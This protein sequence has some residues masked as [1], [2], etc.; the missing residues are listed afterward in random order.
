MNS[1]PVEIRDQIY[2]YFTRAELFSCMMVCKSWFV[3]FMSLFYKEVNIKTM[4]KLE[5]LHTALMLYPSCIQAV[6]HI[7]HLD[8]SSLI[9][10]KPIGIQKLSKILSSCPQLEILSMP[11]RQLWLKHM[12]AN[13]MPKMASLI[14]IDWPKFY[15]DYQPLMMECCAKY[16]S[17][18]EHITLNMHDTARKSGKRGYFYQST[19]CTI[20][21]LQFI[22]SF[23]QLTHL[24]IKENRSMYTT[25]NLFDEIIHLCPNLNTLQYSTR[26]ARMLPINKYPNVQH[27]SL[28]KINIRAVNL[29]PDHIYYIKNKFPNLKDLKL[30]IEE[31]LHDECKS[32]EVLM[33][34]NQ[35]INLD[36][37]ST[38]DDQSTYMEAILMFW[39]RNDDF[40]HPVKHIVKK[41]LSLDSSKVS[42]NTMQLS[43]AKCLSSGL[44]NVVVSIDRATVVDQPLIIYPE[45]LGCGLNELILGKCYPEE[46]PSNLIGDTFPILTELIL[47]NSPLTRFIDS[48]LPFGHII[49]LTL[50]SCSIL[51]S[52]M[53]GIEIG[54][55][56][57]KKLYLQ[58][59]KFSMNELR[60]SS[61][62][63]ESSPQSIPSQRIYLQLPKTGLESF[64][65]HHQEVLDSKVDVLVDKV[66]NNTVLC[67]WYRCIRSRRTMI[68]RGKYLMIRPYE[69]TKKPVVCFQSST[70]RSCTIKFF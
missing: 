30:A 1:L 23:T 37:S 67:R 62:C 36:V 34:L 3:I 38:F 2:V 52:V 59:C 15:S 56:N 4:D 51:D 53:R 31:R 27:E 46:I 26:L 68:I 54:C 47:S 49:K 33:G 60:S 21:V 70:L 7:I 25:E 43:F 45:E 50:S 20:D 22:C 11:S 28:T 5:K 35:L 48:G 64:N 18:I 12:L 66:E 19:N 58:W 65:F 16:R 9:E 13:E 40:T 44:K 42:T 61:D 57:L 41:T 6:S 17:T 24:D 32:M 63:T 69:D 55:P 29:D 10:E 14:E 8:L 39:K